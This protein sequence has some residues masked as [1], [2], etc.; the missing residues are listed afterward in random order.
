[1]YGGNGECVILQYKSEGPVNGDLRSRD[2]ADWSIL[3]TVVDL[4]VAGRENTSS[5]YP[6]QR[7]LGRSFLSTF[8]L[9]SSLGRF[10][11]GI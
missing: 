9:L 8:L 4:V 3:N 2:L 7:W 1:M 10:P 5:G 11:D 6:H